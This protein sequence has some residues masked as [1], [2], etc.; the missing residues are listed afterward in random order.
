ML[1]GLAFLLPTQAKTRLE[2]A[3]QLRRLGALGFPFGVSKS[4]SFVFSF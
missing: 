2:W 4:V 1:A 3:T